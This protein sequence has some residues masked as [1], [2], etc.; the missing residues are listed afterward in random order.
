MWSEV[1]VNIFDGQN[2]LDI[3]FPDFGISPCSTPAS[4]II[5]DDDEEMQ[6]EEPFDET[7]FQVLKLKF[8][9]NQHVVDCCVY[10]K[11]C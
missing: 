2:I 4:T 11:S 7:V 10:W 1:E 5:D 8:W 3:R 9:F 6:D